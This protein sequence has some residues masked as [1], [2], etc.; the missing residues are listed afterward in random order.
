[1]KIR[2][3]LLAATTLLIAVAAEAGP[4]RTERAACELVKARVAATGDFPLSRIAFCDVI[5]RESSPARYYV[6]A[7][8]SN[9]RCEGICSTNMGWFAVERATGRV[10]EWNVAED[11]LGLPVIAG[12]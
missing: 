1:M 11:R 9:R 6:L 7:L 8:H 4:V 12:P 3:I 10:F 5:P 2:A